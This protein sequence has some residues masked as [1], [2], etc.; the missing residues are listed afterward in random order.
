MEYQHTATARISCFSVGI[1]GET[2]A[3]VLISVPRIGSISTLASS[4]DEGL[5][6]SSF[7]KKCDHLDEALL[8]RGL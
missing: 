8:K 3:G 6:R 1:A 7:L 4:R 5:C 2:N